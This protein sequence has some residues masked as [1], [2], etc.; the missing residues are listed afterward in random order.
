MRTFLEATSHGR[1]DDED[2]LE[3]LEN[4]YTRLKNMMDSHTQSNLNDAF[5]ALMVRS[6]SAT[7]IVPKEQQP[8]NQSSKHVEDALWSLNSDLI[9]PASAEMLANDPAELEPADIVQD[10]AKEEVIAEIKEEE[11]GNDS[12]V[13]EPKELHVPAVDE[14]ANDSNV[15]K[16]KELPVPGVDEN[17]KKSNEV[18]V[19]PPISAADRGQ[20][21]DE[22]QPP[23]SLTDTEMQKLIEFKTSLV[24]LGT[25][26]LV[27]MVEKMRK[28]GIQD[29]E[30]KLLRGIAVKLIEHDLTTDQ[31][32]QLFIDMSGNLKAT[33]ATLDDFAR[34]TELE[35]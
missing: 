14:E 15:L 11:K 5:D 21:E 16:A 26:K 28:K 29:L 4:N 12:N 18:D 9:S 13:S 22:T 19:V 31:T 20:E 24:G 23:P 35:I 17:E 2:E 34:W 25:K 30:V 1:L 8:L 6:S 7:K 33:S 3:Q 32:R 27:S 10:E